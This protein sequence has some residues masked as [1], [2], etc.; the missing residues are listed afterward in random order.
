MQPEIFADKIYYYKNVV[1]APSDLVSLIETSDEDLTDNDA[2]EKWSE[3]VASGE[4]PKYVFGQKKSTDE[5]KLS[6]SSE[7]AQTIYSTVKDALTKVGQDYARKNDIEYKDPLPL[8]ISKYATGSAMGPHVDYYG[9]PAIEPLMSAVLY[10]N[11]DVEGGELNFTEF[12]V[13]IKP[14]AGSVVIFPSVAPYYHESIPVLA[15]VKYMA[16]A[17]WIKKL[18]N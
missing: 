8:S 7:V 6:T 4:G 14:E 15:G 13:R 16:P 5:S 10:L 17:F 2:I 3:W 9:D 11:D 12:G 18:T 1:D